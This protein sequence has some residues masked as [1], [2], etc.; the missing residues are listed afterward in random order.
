MAIV[1]GSP[2]D[3]R[4]HPSSAALVVE[5]SD[6]TLAYDSARKASLY[7][8]AGIREY[9]IVD[10]TVGELVVHRNPVA[11]P[12]AEFGG[13]YADL[14]RLGPEDT[15]APLGCPGARISVKDLLP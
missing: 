14:R 11:D 3:Y 13:R 2:R 5:V 6:T 9:W 12:G 10:L 4:D 15:I 1:A 7:A 8:S